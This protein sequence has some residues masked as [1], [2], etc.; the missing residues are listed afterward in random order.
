[1]DV[2]RLAAQHQV[3]VYPISI[4]HNWGYGAAYP[5]Q[6]DCL[7]LDLGRMNRIRSLD[8]ESG[9]VTV[10]P[11]VTQQQLREALDAAG[12]RYLVPVTGAGPHASLLGNALER[13][14]GITPYADHFGALT[15]LEAVLPDGSLY[16]SALAEMGG[17][18]VDAAF[19]WGIGPY[20]DGLFT[21]GGLGVVTAVTLALAPLP[22]RVEAFYFFVNEDRQLDAAVAAVRALLRELGGLAPAINLMNRRRVLSM[23]EPFPAAR[24]PAGNAVP[25][26]VVEAMGRAARAPAWLGVGALYGPARIVRAARASVRRHLAAVPARPL[27]FLNETRC[28]WLGRATGWLPGGLG[29][30]ARRRLQAARAV[31]DIL[32]GQPNE[33]A[34]PLAYWRSGHQPDAGVPLD[35]A[36]DGCGLIWYA[37]LVPM[38]PPLVRRYVDL[39]ER[40]CLQHDL[41]PLI[42]LTSLSS[43]CFD[44]TVPLLFDRQDA[45]AAARAET[46]FRTLFAEGRALGLLPYRLGIQSMDLFTTHAPRFAAL[47]DRLR[48]SVDPQGIVAP[49]RY[50]G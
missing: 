24:V 44:S 8:P 45:L 10:E 32:R 9:L 36:R 41:D 3:P 33:V 30:L 6:P 22:E 19:K 49:G 37:P 11:G 25:T 28:A 46:C 29:R 14:Y 26:E 27:L 4:G 50:G 2:L 7:L 35:P 40:V 5:P 12:L 1:V 43:R 16:R 18:G 39:V 47:S 34:L 20:L 38:A 17:E 23:M 13:G 21:Q 31:L 48:R 15:A 42:T